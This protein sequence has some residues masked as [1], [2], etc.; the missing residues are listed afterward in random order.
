MLTHSPT[1]ASVFAMGLSVKD[2][3]EEGGEDSRV[4]V[5]HCYLNTAFFCDALCD[6]LD[7]KAHIHR[8]ERELIPRRLRLRT[9][10]RF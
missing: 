7:L 4:C 9:A 2:L 8:G 1:E 3:V 6:D 10:P 5:F